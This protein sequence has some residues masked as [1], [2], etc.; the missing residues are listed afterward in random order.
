MMGR[1]PQ[2]FPSGMR[3]DMFMRSMHFISAVMETLNKKAFIVTER[4]FLGMAPKMAREGDAVCILQGGH[5][6]FVARPKGEGYWEFVGKCYVHGIMNGKVVK[7]A[8]R[9]DVQMFQ[10]I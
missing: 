6:P 5:V 2:L 10:L 3:D 4:G 1:F 7:E 8:K 9:K